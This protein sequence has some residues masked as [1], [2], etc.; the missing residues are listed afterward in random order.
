MDNLT[1][2]RVMNILHEMEAAISSDA[3]LSKEQALELLLSFDRFWDELKGDNQL[4][5]KWSRASRQWQLL[6]PLKPYAARIHEQ[7]F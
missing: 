5:E 2:V 7:L 6:P 4:E 3:S 1:R